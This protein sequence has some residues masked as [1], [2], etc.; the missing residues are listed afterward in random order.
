MI[1]ALTAFLLAFSTACALPE[2]S[3]HDAEVV[4]RTT[5]IWLTYGYAPPGDKCEIRKVVRHDSLD[6]YVDACTKGLPGWMMA[7]A[8][9]TAACTKKKLAALEKREYYK[10]H[11]APNYHE[12]DGLLAHETIHWLIACTGNGTKTD[13]MDAAHARRDIWGDLEP[14][15]RKFVN[16]D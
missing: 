2:L 16:N 7:E 1:R 9:R 4:H 6:G 8:R 15:A 13:P 10:V 14:A 3:D 12:D 11:I 5:D